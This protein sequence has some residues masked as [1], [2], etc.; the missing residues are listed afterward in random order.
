MW[1]PKLG[2]PLE[3]KTILQSS[4][5]LNDNIVHAAH[6]LLKQSFTAIE[7]LRSPQLGR[8]LSFKH[9]SSQKKYLQILHVDGNHWIGVSNIGLYS[10]EP[11]SKKA[12]VYDSLVQENMASNTKQQICSFVRPSSKSF[13]FEIMNIMAQQNSS[14]CG[15]FAIANI[16]ELAYGGHP[17]R[18]LWDKTKLR[19]H[20]LTCLEQNRIMPFPK[21]KERRVPFSGAVKYSIKEDIHCICRMPYD[22]VSDMICCCHCLVWFHCSCISIEDVTEYSKKK[23]ICTKCQDLFN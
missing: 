15:L 12:F 4:Q 10:Q 13:R 21:L 11:V 23:W 17:G 1:V 22:N 9:I 2:L 14:D 7:G 6:Q 18:C 19:G 5:W 8:S 3:D 20:L 16:T